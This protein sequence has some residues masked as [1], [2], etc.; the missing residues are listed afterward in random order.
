MAE[1]IFDMDDSTNRTMA[2]SK[3]KNRNYD[4]FNMG[5]YHFVEAVSID[6]PVLIESAI[7]ALRSVI[8]NHDLLFDSC[9]YCL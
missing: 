5:N 1:K 9:I 3:I 8:L 7:F 2:E 4:Q 6:A